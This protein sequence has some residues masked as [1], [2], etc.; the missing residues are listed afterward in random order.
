LRERLVSSRLQA[1]GDVD[2]EG[3]PETVDCDDLDPDV[4]PLARE[5]LCNGRDENCSGR[6]ECDRDGDGVLDHEDLDPDDPDVG[7]P[8]RGEA[9]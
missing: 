6:D 3:A 9:P 7:R 4:G 5:V 1:G 2:G 8:Q